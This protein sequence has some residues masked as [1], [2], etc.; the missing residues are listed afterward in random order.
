MT[1]PRGSGS[2]RLRTG[3]WF[4]RYY[5]HGRRVEESTGFRATERAQAATMLRKKLKA[6]DTDHFIDPTTRRLTFE[7]IAEGLRR[8]YAR[9][10]NRSR[11]AY[12]LAH[13]AETFG[14]WA[15]L[16]ITSEEVERYT[17]ARL[18][19]GAAVGTVNRELAAL[20]RAF[21][22]AVQQQILPRMPHIRLRPEDNARQGFLDPADFDA[23]LAEPRRRDPVVADV[24]E[25]AY[26]TC[27]RRGNVLAL[28]WPMVAPTVRGGVLVDGELRLPGRMTKNRR[29]LTL[30]LTGRLLEVF[31]RRWAER[32][33]T[34]VA[35]FHRTGRPV[36]SFEGSWAAATTAIGRP[37]LLL[38]DLRRSGARVLRRAGIDELTIMALGGWKT[39]SMFARYAI[40]DTT[41]L[42]EAQAK[43]T[44][45]FATSPARRVVPLRRRPRS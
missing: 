38:H 35:I 20:R 31:Q 12:K 37:G 39:R 10:G 14:G 1:R 22:L 8:D 6:A 42:A 27:L 24:A 29:P 36:R 21:R 33:P 13:L 4:M 18:A 16:A 26:F 30:P 9:R 7:D 11:V 43:L 40:T 25:C 44:A 17:D 2:L 23:L 45:A 19:A 28:Q 5:H 41:D 34:C 3:L 15:A 32:H